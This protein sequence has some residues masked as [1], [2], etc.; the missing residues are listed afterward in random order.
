MNPCVSFF[1]GCATTFLFLAI[2]A[3]SRRD[4]DAAANVRL[5]CLSKEDVIE[6]QGK[7]WAAGQ[8][9]MEDGK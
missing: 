2:W 1:I 6:Q 5:G 8:G 7:P 3:L 9:D 4:D